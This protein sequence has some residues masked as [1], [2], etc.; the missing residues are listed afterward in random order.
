MRLFYHPYPT[1]DS[2]LSEEESLHAVKV[3]RLQEGDTIRLM[4]GK[5]YWYDA[6]ITKAHAKKCTFQ[7]VQQSSLAPRRSYR[8][9]IAVAPTK[10]IDRTEWFVEKAVEAGIDEISFLQCEHSE[11]KN[12]NLERFEKIVVSALKQSTNLYLPTLHPMVPFRQFAAQALSSQKFI[13]HLEDGE[14]K[15]LKNELAATDDILI[16]IG[17]EGDFSP[18]EIDFAL[19][20]GFAPVSLGESRL[21]TETA[22]LAACFTCHIVKS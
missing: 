4:D 5:G 9:H 12:I 6:K 13:A 1:S 16:L 21:R 18:E 15:L 10:S 17:P 8:L 22:A 7:I 19:K 2:F 20:Q 11:R 3:L 14:R